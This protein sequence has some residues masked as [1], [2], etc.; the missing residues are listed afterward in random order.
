[1]AINDAK[2]AS[3]IDYA[4][5]VK[6]WP[7]L[8][9]AVEAKIEDQR[10]FVRWWEA[11]LGADLRQAVSMARE[12]ERRRARRTEPIGLPRKPASTRT[13]RS[14]HANSRHCRRSLFPS[15]LRGSRFYLEER[16][17]ALKELGRIEIVVPARR[18]LI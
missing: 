16:K 15:W 18:P 14:R 13:S 17:E 1:M 5:R 11:R 10:E 6:D 12:A 2:A 8:E 9:V 4:K 7:T 3:V